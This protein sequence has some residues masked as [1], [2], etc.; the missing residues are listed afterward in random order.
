MYT[1]FSMSK[2]GLF[3]ARKMKKYPLPSNE[4]MKQL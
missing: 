4:L 2:V 1:I 3:E